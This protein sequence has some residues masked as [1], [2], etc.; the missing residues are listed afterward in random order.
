MAAQ[1]VRASIL[2]ADRLLCFNLAAQQNI[3]RKYG[4]TVK[5]L[6]VFQAVFCGAEATDEAQQ[7]AVAADWVEALT[8]GGKLYAAVTGE[9]S[10]PVSAERFLALCSPFECGE[11]AEMIS[12]DITDG[13]EQE[14]KA[15]E[16]VKK[17]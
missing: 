6:N 2:G 3:S 17:K 7:I 15:E 14:V 13:R 16:N 9:K 1:A 8:Y 4:S 10:E 11:V 12:R 5:A